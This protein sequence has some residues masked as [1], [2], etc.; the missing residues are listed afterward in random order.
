MNK[1]TY[2]ATL[3]GAGLLATAPIA[4]AQQKPGSPTMHN[5]GATH[6]PGAAHGNSPSSAAYMDGMAKMNRD[7]GMPMTGDADRDFAT[8]MIPHHQ[9]AIDMARVQLQHGKDPKLRKMAQQIINDQE[10]EIADFQKWLN[11]HKP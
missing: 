11:Q 4:L 7:M 8:M 1:R 9:G 2:V 6:A 10:K 3:I 5:H